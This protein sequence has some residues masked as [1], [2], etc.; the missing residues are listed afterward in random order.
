V[1]HGAARHVTASHLDWHAGAVKCEREQHTVTHQ[2]MEVSAEVG[3]GQR[4]GVAPA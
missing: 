3:L 1:H 2:A 4:E